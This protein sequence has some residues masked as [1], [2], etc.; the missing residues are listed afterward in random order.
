[1]SEFD[2]TEDHTFHGKITYDE[3]TSGQLP[4]CVIDGKNISWDQLGRELMTCE[5][6]HFEM[7]IYED[8]S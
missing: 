3:N 1:M 7:K 4:M 5:G 6:F 2:I 8:G